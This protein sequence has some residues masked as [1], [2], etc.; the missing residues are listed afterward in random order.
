[1]T[2][3]PEDEQVR[4]LRGLLVD[5]AQHLLPD[6]PRLQTLQH[7]AKHGLCSLELEAALQSE[8]RTTQ[9][10]VRAG[11]VC[12]LRSLRPDTLEASLVA[13][14]KESALET[15]WLL[16]RVRSRLMV[17]LPGGWTEAQLAALMQLFKMEDT[18][19]VAH[20]GVEIIRSLT[21]ADQNEMLLLFISEHRWTAA[22]FVATRGDMV[23][24]EWFCR[25]FCVAL[26]RE[27]L[28]RLP[29]AQRSDWEAFLREVE[30]QE[31]AYTKFHFHLHRLARQ[32]ST[33]E[34]LFLAFTRLKNDRP[35]STRTQDVFTHWR[36]AVC[37]EDPRRHTECGT[38]ARQIL[39]ELIQDTAAQ[40]PVTQE[41]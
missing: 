33:W 23:Q 32:Q 28:L 17:G 21:A 29:A 40:Q 25:R 12:M 13:L 35:I 26:L 7:L 9:G 41:G 19:E 36:T 31:Y 20:Q 24:T 4:Q 10:S 11:L 34:P 15:T 22:I 3:I 5:C 16:P 8:R 2:G 39:Y 14:A 18:R 30:Q 27:L 6:D 37:S 38:M 1:M